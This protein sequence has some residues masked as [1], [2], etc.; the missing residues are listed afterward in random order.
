MVLA[1]SGGAQAA[2][3]AYHDFGALAGFESTGNITTHQSGPT[4]PLT[5]DTTPKALIRYSDGGATGV[6]FSVAGANGV[7]IRNGGQIAPPAGGT[8]ADPLFNV[9]GLNLNNGSIFEGGNSGS[10]STTFTLTGLNA[11][12]TYDVALYGS[13]EGVSTDGVE[14]FTLGG[15]DAA[16]NSSS[17][18]II[19]AFITDQNTRGKG[20]LC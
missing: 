19:G 18:G 13:R 5:L 8:P 7:D 9:A 20:F 17:T 6:T 3:V 1:L 16:T 4:N 10:G 12:L 14:R 2:F 15:A 11:S